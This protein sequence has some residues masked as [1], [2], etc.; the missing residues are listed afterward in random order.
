MA[1]VK[2]W[3]TSAASNNSASPDGAPEGMAPSGLNDTIRENMSAVARWYGDTNGSLDTTGSSNAYLLAPN[4]TY[5]AY[6]RGDSFAVEANHTNTG[7]A[8][9]NVSSL[10]A[11][12][13]VLTN[14][15]ALTGD[16]IQSGGIYF[17]HYDGTSFQILNPSAPTSR[18]AYSTSGVESFGFSK[19][20]TASL[21]AQDIFTITFTAANTALEVSVFV[22]DTTFPNGG[23]FQKLYI[24]A[25]G[26]G[27][28]LSEATIAVEDKVRRPNSTLTDYLTW[29]VTEVNT[30]VLTVRA[31]ATETSGSL[32]IT[33]VV[34]GPNI[35]SVDPA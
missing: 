14:G 12:A 20:I 8:T 31:V 9:L 25:Y 34:T 24:A 22:S 13:I 26:S 1:D 23:F 32:T 33:G 16:E 7:A 18:L 2:T 6:A 11:K 27:F 17:L 21:S 15:E 5:A 29:T 28:N 30:A 4:A 3:N 35:G 10:G 19:T